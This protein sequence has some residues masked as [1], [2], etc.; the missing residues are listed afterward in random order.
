MQHRALPLSQQYAF[1]ALAPVLLVLLA[2][3]FLG[4]R[5]GLRAWIGIAL[6]TTGLIV[7]SLSAV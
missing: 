4:E 5:L 6:I 1:D 2:V 3:L 7:I